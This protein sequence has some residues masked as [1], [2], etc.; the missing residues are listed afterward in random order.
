M[1]EYN[2]ITEK[3]ILQK[4]LRKSLIRKI[5][6]KWRKGSILFVGN[7]YHVLPSTL[8]E[9]APLENLLKRVG[10]GLTQLPPIMFLVK[11]GSAS[12]LVRLLCDHCTLFDVLAPAP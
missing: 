2:H 9:M 12:M 6:A 7:Q 4:K 5:Y 11:K 10:A 3:K 1:N 8:V